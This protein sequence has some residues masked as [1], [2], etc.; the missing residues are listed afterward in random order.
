MS[1]DIKEIRKQFPILNQ[2]INGKPLVYL[3]N[4]ASSQKPISVVNALSN[5]YLNDHANVHR[6]VHTLSQRATDQFEAV[7]K[8]TQQ[9]INAEQEK[10]IIFTRGT[11]EARRPSSRT[12]AR[13]TSRA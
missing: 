4:G 6:G 10:E 3:D 5:Y 7:R 1:I 13:V 11:T 12:G 2:W 9:F 8:L